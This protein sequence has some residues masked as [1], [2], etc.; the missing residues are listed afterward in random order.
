[1]PLVSMVFPQATPFL[2][3]FMRY[4]RTHMWFGGHLLVLLIMAVSLG[5]K[6][7]LLVAWANILAIM[8]LLAAPF[9]FNPFSLDWQK[10]KVGAG[11]AGLACV[12]S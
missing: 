12:L 7:S 1:M 9:W 6:T 3:V 4:G 8:S 2:E 5:L 11:C 10:N